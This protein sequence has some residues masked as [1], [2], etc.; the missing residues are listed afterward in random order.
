[1]TRWMKNIQQLFFQR[2][3]DQNGWV[4]GVSFIQMLFKSLSNK[5]LKTESY[6]YV[7]FVVTGGTG[8][9]RYDNNHFAATSSKVDIVIID[10]DG[11]K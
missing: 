4:F 11:R 5:T 3:S 2:K 9:Y 7:S 8:G 10:G 6:H 1:M